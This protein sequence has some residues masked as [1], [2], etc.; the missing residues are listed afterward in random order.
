M[1]KMNDT[2]WAITLH[3]SCPDIHW[4]ACVRMVDTLA[5]TSSFWL[6]NKTFFQTKDINIQ[7]KL[8]HIPW[9]W[10]HVCDYCSQDNT[11]PKIILIVSH[12]TLWQLHQNHE[13]N[14]NMYEQKFTQNIFDIERFILALPIWCLFRESMNLLELMPIQTYVPICVTSLNGLVHPLMCSED[15]H[16]NVG[17]HWM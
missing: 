2:S 5:L 10:T 9:L 7:W 12:F 17:E 3:T 11:V 16:S 13:T 1:E 15:V 6:F 8:L 14:Q 4:L